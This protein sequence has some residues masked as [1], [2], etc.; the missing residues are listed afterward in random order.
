MTQKRS[1]DEFNFIYLVESSKKAFRKR[2]LFI[3]M[4]FLGFFNIFTMR[5]DLSVAIVAMVKSG[6]LLIQIFL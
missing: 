3:V 1:S 4:S 5:V 2:V 6:N